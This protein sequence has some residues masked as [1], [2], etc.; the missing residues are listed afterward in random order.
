[1]ISQTFSVTVI[2]YEPIRG[3]IDILTLHME[4]ATK[5]SLKY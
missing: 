5:L 2:I 1:M 4:A 3:A